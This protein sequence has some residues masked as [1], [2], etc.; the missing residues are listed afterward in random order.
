[1]NFFQELT[2]A[3]Q[4]SFTQGDISLLG[5]RVTIVHATFWAE[6]TLKINND[7]KRV[8]ELY[9]ISKSSFRDGMSKSIG[10]KYGLSFNDFFKWL[11][12]IAM[13]AGWGKLTWLDLNEKNKNGVISVEN[14]P[15]VEILKNKVNL[16]ID[17]LIRGFIAGGASGWLNADIDAFES[18]CAATGKNNCKFIFKP[19]GEFEIN[20]ETLRQL[21]IK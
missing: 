12:N 10:K 4:I 17:H 13:F 15:V 21:G 1:M 11:T 20:P 18:E 9:E 14:S 16:P 2:L 3:K 6:Y 19:K 5:N 8:L 7:P